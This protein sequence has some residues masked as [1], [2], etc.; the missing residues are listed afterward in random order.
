[1]SMVVLPIET[2]GRDLA[3]PVAHADVRSIKMAGAIINL[4]KHTPSVTESLALLTVHILMLLMLK[5]VRLW[6]F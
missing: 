3:L 2:A 4:G 5:C 6:S 1:M